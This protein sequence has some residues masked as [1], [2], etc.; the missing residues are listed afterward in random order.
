MPGHAVAAANLTLVGA[1]DGK[2]KYDLGESRS[3]KVLTLVY[4]ASEPVSSPPSVALSDAKGE[5]GLFD[6]SLSAAAEVV[7]EGIV[8]VNVTVEPGSASP[9]T[10][11]SEVLLRGG[12]IENTST[13]LVLV[14]SRCPSELGAVLIAIVLLI[15]GVGLGCL[16]KWLSGSGTK[17]RL[18]LARYEQLSTSFEGDDW[19]PHA[20]KRALAEIRVW[21]GMGEAD[22]A[23]EKLNA[24]AEK[25]EAVLAVMQLLGSLKAKIDDTAARVEKLQGLDSSAEAHLKDAIKLERDWLEQ[26]REEAYPK[27][28]DGKES[29]EEKAGWIA[30]F[31][32][33]FGE[34]EDPAKRDGKWNE[35]LTMYSRGE[36]AAA[37]GKWSEPG[38]AAAAEPTTE[39][40]SLTPVDASFGNKVKW[41]AIRHSPALAGLLIALGI[42]VVGLQTVFDPKTMFLEDGFRDGLSLIAWGFGS[43]L[44]GLT[45]TELASKVMPK[46]SA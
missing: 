39:E 41:W 34:Y 14:F 18:L 21:L 29:R 33:F 6:G 28:E 44:V 10:Y 26:M 3:N 11:T 36:F 37:K 38:A 1:E 32:A 31:G 17:L 22:S 45:T 2:A 5:D 8:K 16:L 42:V 35:A 7:G 15:T 27:P 13:P 43:A 20:L 25:A 40:P 9:G 12:K 30:E 46:S 19:T 24:V 4:S 23:E